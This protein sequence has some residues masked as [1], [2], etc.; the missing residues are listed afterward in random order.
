MNNT[1]NLCGA[2]TL[3]G[4]DSSG[5]ETSIAASVPGCVHTDLIGAGVIGDIFYRDNSLSVQWIEK[6]NYTY[7]KKFTV[8]EPLPSAFLELDGFT[9]YAIID[10]EYLLSDNCFTLKRGETRRLTKILKL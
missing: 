4:P 1:I 5:R 2:W 3:T 7:T 8:D 6:G 9:P 10:S